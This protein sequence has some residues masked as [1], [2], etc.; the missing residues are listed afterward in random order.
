VDAHIA[1]PI[2]LFICA[3]YGLRILTDA[4][5]RYLLVRSASSVEMIRTVLRE[6]SRLR[7]ESALRWGLILAFGAA[8]LA[9]LQWTGWTGLNPGPVGLVAGAIAIAN[10]MFYALSSRIGATAPVP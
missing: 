4:V 1:I 3:T 5:M 7:R 9:I 10:L 2:T 8:A 6:E